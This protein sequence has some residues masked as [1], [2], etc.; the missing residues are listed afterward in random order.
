[1][2]VYHHTRKETDDLWKKIASEVLRTLAGRTLKPTRNLEKKQDKNIY[3][4]C[5]QKMP[6]GINQSSAQK[7]TKFESHT[8]ALCRKKNTGKTKENFG[9]NNRKKNNNWGDIARPTRTSSRPT[10]MESYDRCPM[11]HLRHTR[12]FFFF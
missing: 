6:L 1:M 8:R 12:K 5:Y 9:K 2:D 10:K 4:R 7:C 11:R 3:H